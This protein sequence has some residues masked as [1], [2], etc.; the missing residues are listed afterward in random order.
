MSSGSRREWEW[1]RCSKRLRRGCF[2]RQGDQEGSGS[3]GGYLSPAPGNERRQR[4]REKTMEV[5][6]ELCA[7]ADEHR[8]EGEKR[9]TQC[10]VHCAVGRTVPVLAAAS[11]GVSEWQGEL[12][13]WRRGW[14]RGVARS[15]RPSSEHTLNRGAGNVQSA[16]LACQHARTNAVTAWTV[17]LGHPKH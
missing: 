8:R 16:R 1:L 13:R 11:S 4:E 3:A 6:Q 2:Y 10:V 15:G 9:R 12:W 14:W 7:G 17:T 5:T